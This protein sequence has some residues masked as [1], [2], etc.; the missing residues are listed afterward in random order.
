MKAFWSEKRPNG[1]PIEVGTFC[2]VLDLEDGT[3]PIYVYGATMD[4]VLKKIE[5]QNGNAQL[6][7]VRR[8]SQ[9]TQEP[10]TT[11]VPSPAQFTYAPRFRLTPDQVM[12]Y[13]ADLKD[14][15]KSGEAIIMLQA[16]ENGVDPK[17]AAMDNFKKLAFEWENEHPEFFPHKGNRN[18]I[19]M[20]IAQ[21]TE[22]RPQLATKE[23]L[24]Q[25]YRELLNEG[26][27]FEEPEEINPAPVDGAQPNDTTPSTFPAESQV[28]RTER[29]RRSFATGAPA[30]SLRAR[31]T[32][33]PRT[34]KYTE[35]QVLRMPED[36]RKRLLKAND[37]DYLAAA[38]FYF[39][40]ETR[41]AG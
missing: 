36:Q 21:K 32:A 28:Q 14:P 27:L 4:E 1:Q 26:L 19:G 29:P 3:H 41:R 40:T 35:E 5:R 24:T 22:G 25:C 9:P 38:D 12:Q 23:L 17:R 6:A 13:N 2:R 34:L 11:T 8:N 15:A 20:R 16:H 18:A 10:G 7:L 31:Q 33:Q 37:K 39:Q 30:T